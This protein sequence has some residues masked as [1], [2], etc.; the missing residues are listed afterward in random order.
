MKNCEIEGCLKPYHCRGFCQSHLRKMKIYGDPTAPDKRK[1][2]PHTFCQICGVQSVGHGLCSKH[3]TRLLR[4]GDPDYT[5][6]TRED[7]YHSSYERKGMD[8][9][10]LWT[11]RI[12]K[13]GYGKLGFKRFHTD[14]AHRYGWELAHNQPVPKGMLVCHTCDNPSCQNPKHLFIGTQKDNVADSVSKG[15]HGRWKSKP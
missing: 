9:C 5:E 10:W 1:C 2:K 3:Y 12:D 4:H 6:K 15:R 8:E 13:D 7:I 11:K 14:R